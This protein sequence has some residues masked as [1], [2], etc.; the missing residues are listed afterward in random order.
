MD[1]RAIAAHLTSATF[2]GPYTKEA[3]IYP[4]LKRA[5]QEA[6]G[7]S[8]T[9]HVQQRDYGVIR[10]VE[11]FAQAFWPDGNVTVGDRR[12][13]I[14]AKLLRHAQESGTLASAV[15]QGMVLTLEYDEVLLVFVTTA[16]ATAFTPRE[17]AMLDGLWA[18]NRI[19]WTSVPAHRSAHPEATRGSQKWIQRL[20]NDCPRIL[21]EAIAEA[22]RGAID[23]P[24]RWVSP[25][26][27]EGYVE[28]RDQAFLE[29]LGVTLRQ[30]SL[31]S[32]WPSG[33]PV[34]DGLG[35]TASGAPI[36]VEA[37]AHARETTSPPS[38]ASELSLARIRTSLAEV[39]ARLDID[40]AR[41]WTGKYFQ[42]ANRL[43]H[44]HLLRE[45][46]RIPA[47][48][49]FLYLVGDEDMGGPTTREEWDSVER[50]IHETLGI[51][52]AIPHV[53]AVHVDVGAIAGEAPV[54]GAVR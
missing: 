36:L 13:G 49:V 31:S 25:L 47:W 5:L 2:P 18:S 6:A 45:L 40:P 34:W 39:Q 51:H 20:V 44:L 28:Y 16:E 4:D 8:A 54:G 10:P 27:A 22:S 42:Y 35:I 41:D 52:D 53:L 37:K 7:T 50:E 26:R 38:K 46:N 24:I 21:D 33:G 17:R 14:E 15:F 43:A 12:I 19:A 11:A 9:V 32:F 23:L 1:A 48:L 30:R 29:R 3:E